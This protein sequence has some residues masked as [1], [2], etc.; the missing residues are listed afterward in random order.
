MT[1]Y[2]RQCCR[3][4]SST[5][6]PADIALTT[7]AFTTYETEVVLHDVGDGVETLDLL[8]RLPRPMLTRP[9]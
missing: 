9:A 8:R 3:C 1:S 4:C 5:T 7:D 6:T 2:S